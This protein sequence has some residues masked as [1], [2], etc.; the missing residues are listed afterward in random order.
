[1]SAL[2]S[3][4]DN[5][6]GAF[7]FAN[8]AS[9]CRVRLLRFSALLLA[10]WFSGPQARAQSKH[11]AF[12]APGFQF[13]QV[14]TICVM[15]VIDARQD[16]G[17]PLSRPKSLRITLNAALEERGYQTDRQC[18]DGESDHA[19]RAGGWRWLFTVRVDALYVVGAAITGSLY[20]TQADKEVWKDSAIPGFGGRYKNALKAQAGVLNADELVRSSFHALLAT[21]EDRKKN[22]R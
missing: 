10:V 16:A 2:K 1:M 11:P 14:D 13:S 12:M 22:K 18:S 7:A 3:Y 8:G 9:A 4:E 5:V 19:P 17:P 21:F 6:G 20:D 15:P